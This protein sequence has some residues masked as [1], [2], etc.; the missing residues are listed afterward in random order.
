LGGAS[1][2]S[3]VPGGGYG[4]RAQAALRRRS[5][6]QERRCGA[7]AIRRAGFY[8]ARKLAESRSS[9]ERRRRKAKRDPA[10][11]AKLRRAERTNN[12]RSFLRTQYGISLEDYDAMLAQQ[13]G[14]CAICRKRSAKRL[15]VDHCHVTR[16]VRGLLCKKCNFGLGHFSDDPDLVDAAAVYLR[17][18]SG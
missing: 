10:Y 16:T 3:I 4:I 12:R 5:W 14:V 9:I 13:G 11:R 8:R 18:A 17:R 2:E 1:P 6:H 15:C 7:S